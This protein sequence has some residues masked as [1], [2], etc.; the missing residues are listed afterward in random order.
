MIY[1]ILVLI[2]LI[3][4]INKRKLP[5]KYSV[6]IDIFDLSRIFVFDIDQSHEISFHLSI[7][8]QVFSNYSHCYLH[9]TSFIYSLRWHKPVRMCLLLIS[10]EPQK[11]SS[12]SVL[13]NVH[14]HGHCPLFAYWP[15]KISSLEYFML[16]HSCDKTTTTHF[17]MTAKQ[18]NFPNFIFFFLVMTLVSSQENWSEPFKRSLKTERN[19]SLSE[20]VSVNTNWIFLVSFIYDCVEANWRRWR[21][22]IYAYSWD[23]EPARREKTNWITTKKA[24]RCSGFLS[25]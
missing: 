5:K 18:R 17:M 21:I 16:P 19:K 1:S 10:V 4:S 6:N 14:S 11:N 12:D 25:C 23:W 13:C 7:N 2:L 24:E 20:R 15:P 3:L 8:S 9:R 22:S